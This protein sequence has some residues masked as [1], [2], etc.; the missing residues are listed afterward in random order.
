[1]AGCAAEHH[2]LKVIKG[3][4]GETSTTGR[5][6][7]QGGGN[8]LQGGGAGD[9]IVWVRDVGNFGGNEEEGGR[10]VHWVT[11]KFHGEASAEVRR[12]EVGDA[13][14]GRSAG[15]SGNA[16][17][18]DLH[19]ETTGS[20]GTVGGATPT[21]YSVCKGNMVRRGRAKEVGLVEK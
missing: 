8:V 5:G 10:E 7:T 3:E 21:I 4:N 14:S 16:V 19:R 2:A 13:W 15:G 11:L 20:R 1:M 9:P 6:R 18:D 12:W 17:D